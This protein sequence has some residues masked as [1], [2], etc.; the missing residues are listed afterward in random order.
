VLIVRKLQVGITAGIILF[1]N[2]TPFIGTSANR[3]TVLAT[4]TSQE[5]QQTATQYYQQGIAQYQTSQIDIAIQ[6]WQQALQ[7]FRQAND[8][9]GELSALGALSAG[10]IALGDYRQTIHYA[11]QQQAIAQANNNRSAQAQALGNLGAAYK[12]LGDY[13]KALATHQQALILFREL[14]DRQSEGILLRNLGNTYTVIG[15]YDQALPLY[16]QSLAIAKELKN[17]REEGNALANLGAIHTN[18]GNDRKALQLY[19]KSLEI[20]ESLQDLPLQ[21]SILINL[22]TTY[23]VIGLNNQGIKSYQ[24]GLELAQQLNDRILQGDVLSNLGMIYEDE[25]NYE[26][27]IQAH[28]KSVE[29]AQSSHNPRSEALSRNNLGYAL[30]ANH[31]LKAAEEQLR[32]AIKLLDQARLG[33]GDLAQVNLLDTQVSTYNLLQQVLIAGNRPE[34][35]LEVSE[36][37][38]ARAFAQLLVER[39][40]KDTQPL[41]TA[42][43][44][45][46]ATPSIARIRQI[47]KQQNATI[48]SYSII[49]DD[50]FKFRGKQR[51]REAELL[52]WVIRP[53]GEIHFRQVDLKPLWKKGTTLQK[54][55]QESRCLDLPYRCNGNLDPNGE[56]YPGLKELYSLLIAPISNVLPN[57]PEES[58]VLIPQDALFLVPFAAL[59]TPEGKFL[60]E[61]H[62]LRS[63]PSIQVLALTHQQSQ[64]QQVKSPRSPS[65]RSAIVVGNPTMPK[66]VVKLGRPPQQ[67]PPLPNSER[68]AQDIAQ[69]LNVTALIGP[70]A[71]KADVLKQ[72]ANV[73]FVHL[74]THGLLEYG[75]EAGSLQAQ[76]PGAIA[77]APSK[78]DDGLLTASEILGLKLKAQLVVLSA[79][80]TGQGKITGDGVIGLSRSWIATGVPSVIV[81]LVPVPDAPTADL[82]TAFYQDLRQTSN[83]ARSLRHAMLE[84]MQSHPEPVNW[85]TFILVG[86]AEIGM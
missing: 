77:L 54:L 20:A 1:I 45:T 40:P 13:P 60:I 21:A 37:G 51:G 32:S 86:E 41:P 7:L 4:T 36:E 50:D 57:N 61:S 42:A 22:G 43:P 29:I 59:Q 73:D 81:S 10:Y 83:A 19:Q 14:N 70:K 8:R 6:S 17:L 30:L 3:S 56:D 72:L 11:Q 24:K 64:R 71:T 69:L 47:A 44:A 39:L 62:T 25:N 76:V 35:A 82:M 58:V 38:R 2:L 5:Q 15:D 55:I 12:N 49:P 53:T 9:A 78:D 48:V 65:H 16:Q 34:A 23:H 46:L 18:L 79:C 31:S 28:Q 75:T 33:L 85:A 63:A 66:I 68:E 80:D 26:R 74:A 84:T 27:A 52:I 67:L